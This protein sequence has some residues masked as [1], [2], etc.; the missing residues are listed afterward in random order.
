MNKLKILYGEHKQALLDSCLNQISEHTDLWPDRRAFLI[1]PETAKADTERRFFSQNNNRGLLMAEVLSFRRFAYRLFSEAGGLAIDHISPTG[2]I[3]LIQS[4]L[5]ENK[6]SFKRFGRFAERPGYAAGI[7]SVLGDFRRYG[8]AAEDLAKASEATEDPL[9]SDKLS[10]FSLLARSFDNKLAKLELDDHSLDIDR[11]CELIR[12]LPPRLKFLKNSSIWIYGFGESRDFTAQEHLLIDELMNCAEQLTITVCADTVPGDDILAKAG[13]AVYT[14]GRQTS[15]RLASKASVEV[16]KVSSARSAPF[17]AVANWL[18]HEI[19]PKPQVIG[20]AIRLIRAEDKKQE[21]Y[22]TAGEIR[23]LITEEN[24]RYQDIAVAVCDLPAWQFTL[25]TVFREFGLDSFIDEQMPLNGTALMRY[26]SSLLQL[27]R[28]GDRFENLMA[29]LRTGLTDSPIQNIDQ[30]ENYCLALG[31]SDRGR[32]RDDRF[33]TDRYPGQ[34]EALEFKRSFVDPLLEFAR[35]ISASASVDNR[36]NILIRYLTEQSNVFI[37]TETLAAKWDNAGEN[38]AAASLVQAWNTLLDLLTEMSMIFFDQRISLESFT[39]ILAAGMAGSFSRVIPTGIDRIRISDVSRMSQYFP[40][41][42]F[43]VG[44][45]RNSLPSGHGTEGVL[46]NR[47]R[48]QLELLSGKSFPDMERYHISAKA[49][50]V[51]TLLT[52][53]SDRLYLSCPSLQDSPSIYQQRLFDLLE[54][55]TVLKSNGDIDIRWNSP[56]RAARLCR[57]KNQNS[58]HTKKANTTVNAIRSAFVSSGRS[59]CLNSMS[60]KH[61]PLDP[62]VPERM[63]VSSDLVL[64]QYHDNLLTSVSR[65]Q[66]YQECP[67]SHFASYLLG[68]R[69]RDTNIQDHRMSGTIL[70]ALIERA[71]SDLTERMKRTCTNEESRVEFE[72]WRRDISDHYIQELCWRELAEGAERSYLDVFESKGSG[73]I[74]RRLALSSIRTAAQQLA[75]DEYLPSLMEWEFPSKVSSGLRLRVGS[76][77]IV[78]RGKIDRVDLHADG[79]HYRI[80]DYKSG[81]TEFDLT[82]VYYGMNLQLPI[83]LQAFVENNSMLEPGDLGYFYF[84]KPVYTSSK[85]LAVPDDANIL[86]RVQREKWSSWADRSPDSLKIIGKYAV[87]KAATVAEE[88]FTGNVSAKPQCMNRDNVPCIWCEYK[89]LCN[90]DDRVAARR[91]V[92]LPDVE[93]PSTYPGRETLKRSEV[94]A[95]R[96]EFIE[97]LMTNYIEDHMQNMNHGE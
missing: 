89:A 92:V 95:A 22:F 29:L 80:I 33:Y 21:L 34:K 39:N 23:R 8:I 9:L 54:R 66:K 25:Q 87:V 97:N 11:L 55:E 24:Y 7:D 4:L 57:M 93:L 69:E 30:F 48:Q 16:E 2:R 41:I 43:V 84:R 19:R 63:S 51:Y 18:G 15:C 38:H 42:L 27:G 70:H 52:S 20:D 76:R 46:L 67:Y 59:S 3:M 17:E 90:Y 85:S 26:V 37:N 58:I 64:E 32:Y 31:L 5:R 40:K 77:D 1:V 47:E 78:L 75:P 28:G 82:A 61:E 6:N 62:V 35:S 14:H 44:A 73:R 36:V 74:L 10:D 71:F 79:K 49:N 56:I 91:A 45:T 50:E 88:I 60:G 53:P 96:N 81:S 94:K 86:E 83:Y 68:L 72:K 12:Q 13:P 65:I